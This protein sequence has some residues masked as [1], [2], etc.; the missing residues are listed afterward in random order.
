VLELPQ[1]CRICIR[2]KARC[3]SDPSQNYDEA[4][5]NTAVAHSI[6][7]NQVNGTRYFDGY[8][9]N[10][11]F[12]DGLVLT[13]S[14]FAEYDA[15]NMWTPKTYSGAYGTNGFYL[16]FNDPSA[17]TA[18]S[19]GA[20]RSG[21]GN[22]WT[23]TNFSVTA[24][25]TYDVMQDHPLLQDNG[26]HGGG[27]V[28]TWNAAAAQSMGGGSTVPTLLA[29]NLET[30]GTAQAGSLQATFGLTSGEWY[31]EMTANTIGGLSRHRH[32]HSSEIG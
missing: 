18:A 6:G 12:V 15:Y 17:A 26:D 29:G 23:P 20:D 3:S 14:S 19:L 1:A 30:N 27:N 25:S 13:S 28:A 5:Y 31:W 32:H 16:D 24:G 10:I 4:F 2:L 8:M 22:N 9:A 21:N 7:R 11:H